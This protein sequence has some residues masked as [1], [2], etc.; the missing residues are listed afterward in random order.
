MVF[1]NPA[2][3][4]GL[5]AA[6]IPLIIHLF[7]FRKPRKVDFS[8]LVFVRELQ[9]TTMQ[10]VR[11]KQWILLALRTLAIAALI[12]SFARPSVRG[13]LATLL[14]GDGSRAVGI[15]V[16]NSL[17][18]MLRNQGGDLI[19]QVRA[20]AETVVADLSPADEVLLRTTA[21]SEFGSSVA[22]ASPGTA[23]ALLNEVVAEGGGRSLTR[24][25]ASIADRLAESSRV[26]REL[27][28][29]TDF[30]ESTFDDSTAHLK[31]E[32]TTVRVVPVIAPRIENVGVGSVAVQSRIVEVGQPITITANL[33]NYGTT[34]I[35]GYV[36]SVFLEEDR[37][38][39]ASVTL[40]PGQT[41]Q[42]EFVVTPP[43]RGWLAGVIRGEDD[44]FEFD[45]ERYFTIHVP[46]E[47]RILVVRG[48][49]QS[50]DFVTLALS[51]ELGRDRITFNYDVI[52]ESALPATQAEN[53][54][55][56]VL[57]G[58][59]SLSS[60]EIAAL[61]GY[62][63]DG[64][65]LM[66]FPGS[67]TRDEELTALLAAVG[68]GT[69]A[70]RSGAIGS[71]DPVAR[72]ENFELEHD[73][74]DGVFDKR[75]G[76]RQS[77]EQPDVYAAV[78]YQP[79]RGTEQTLIRLSSGAPF[80]QE[81]RKGEGAT[82]L[83]ASAPNT[84]W[85][86]FPVRGLFVPLLYRAIFYLS[87]SESTSGEQLVVGRPSEF[88][89]TGVSAETRLSVRA[90]DGQDFIPEQRSLFSAMLVSVNE[91]VRTPGVYDVLAGDALVRRIAFNLPEEESD[92][93]SLDVDDAT[94]R[95]QEKFGTDVSVIDADLDGP[96]GLEAQL[97]E[98][99][100]GVELWNVFL[101]IALLLLLIEMLVEKFW[102]PEVAD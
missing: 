66:L 74:F 39:Q 40:A 53:Y 97:R 62:V 6:G 36:A 4:L 60:G 3:L 68:G 15:L 24:S 100:L 1:L 46:E 2:I 5:L 84:R 92:L 25:I 75:A 11:I 70:G 16:D 38:G 41:Q 30:Q 69:V 90:P 26:N 35:D 76:S 87:A 23:T 49:N 17:S 34:N 67:E 83:F 48:E 32:G 43:Q 44:D 21:G 47:R 29:L 79:A 37:V 93:R 72:I 9:K 58:L 98:A 96:D 52:D 82:L 61:S 10:R 86:D 14:G 59:K 81:M 101:M 31:I 94:S 54:D 102:K 28:V 89:V 27:Y 13:S 56:V 78:N 85:T 55:T 50:V 65:G 8:S 51:R 12:I 88:R 95:L 91:Q 18:M 20:A 19:N 99:R 73:L 42:V 33:T 71:A 77:V 57:I 63:E 7:N 22:M 45:N 80:L 64:G